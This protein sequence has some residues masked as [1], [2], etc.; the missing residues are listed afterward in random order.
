MRAAIINPYLNSLGGGE[1]YTM[2]VVTS[3]RNAG[4]DVD[5]QWQDVTLKNQLEKRFGINLQNVNFIEDVKKGDG[6]DYC[7]WV[8]DGSI[9]L[10]RA[11]NNIIHF[12]VP[13]HDVDGTTLMNKMKLYRVKK[14]ISNSNFTKKVIDKEFGVDS[15]VVYPPVDIKAIKPKRKENIILGVARFSQLKQAKRQDILIKAFKKLLKKDIEGWEL[16]LAGGAE[17]GA[18]SFIQELRESAKGYPIRI[19]ESP[20]FSQ[21]KE[22]YGISRIF[23]SASGY[24]VDEKKNPEEVEHFGITVVEAMSAKGVPVVYAAGGHKE[25]VRNGVNGYLYTSVDELVGITKTLIEDSKKLNKAAFNAL[26]SSK[27]F[28]YDRFEKDIVEQFD[29]K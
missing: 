19:M 3:L 24:G 18:G 29:L 4:V 11:R 26:S 13:F 25:T 12:Q 9:P 1:R 10:M 28:G 2:A 8:S 16:V 14:I 6:Y 23:W 22:L 15:V 7:F 17:V 5:V 27:K 20:A 21:I